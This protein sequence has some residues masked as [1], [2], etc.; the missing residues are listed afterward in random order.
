MSNISHADALLGAFGRINPSVGRN[1]KLY[2]E[3]FL[4]LSIDKRIANR[5]EFI[6]YTKQMHSHT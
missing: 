4:R 3:Y 5:S 6:A 2:L 1:I